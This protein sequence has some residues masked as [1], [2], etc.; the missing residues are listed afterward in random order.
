MGG[1]N[2]TY[3]ALGGGIRPIII[4]RRRPRREQAIRAERLAALGLADIVDRT[5]TPDVL[6]RLV[7]ECRDVSPEELDARGIDLDGVTRV[8]G[9][10]VSI[11]GGARIT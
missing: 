2:S 9:L 1:Y 11:A 10:L 3:E 7:G 8:V 4:P 5:D 6:R